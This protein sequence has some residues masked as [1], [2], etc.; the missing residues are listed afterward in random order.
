ML[1][2]LIDAGEFV[3][4]LGY[5]ESGELDETLDKAEKKIYEVTSTPTLSKFTRSAS[6]LRTPGPALS[7][8]QSTRM[9]C[10]ACARAL[11]SSIPCWQAFKSLT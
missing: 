3:A 9:S 5:D 4:E 2:N 11:K 7:I 1:R 10:A 6:R 8:S